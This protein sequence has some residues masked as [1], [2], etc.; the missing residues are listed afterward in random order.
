MSG[1][2]HAKKRRPAADGAAVLPSG[3][4]GGGIGL[5]HELNDI[6]SAM[7]EILEHSRSQTA[8]MTSM[9]GEIKHLRDQCE[10]MEK[11]LQGVDSGCGDQI[12]AR[13][14]NVENRQK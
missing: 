3:Q 7:K 10:S 11:A 5:V 6:K 4:D 14:E 8:I 12:V 1:N 9:Q 13:L 2:N